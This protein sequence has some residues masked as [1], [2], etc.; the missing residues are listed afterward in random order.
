MFVHE[1]SNTVPT[2]T[3][4]RDDLTTLLCITV[5]PAIVFDKLQSLKSNK[6]PGPDEWPS[7]ILR[8]CAELLCVPLAMLFNKSLETGLLPK[9]WKIWHITPIFKKG[10][11]VKVNNYRLVCLTSVIIKLLESIVK[12]ALLSHLYHYNLLSNKQHGFLPHRSCCTQ[13]L[14]ALNIGHL[15]WIRDFQLMLAMYF[16]FSKALIVC[17]TIGF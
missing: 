1:D 2:F 12:D 17:L 5:T 9:D 8:N 14:C 4:G 16:D 13:L 10:S 6:S 11:K 15:L 7:V 3:T